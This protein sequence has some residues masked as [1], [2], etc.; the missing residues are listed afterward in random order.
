[1]STEII[2]YRFLARGGDAAAVI[3]LNEIP[4]RREII[5]EIDTQKFKVGDGVTPYVSLPY[6]GGSGGGGSGAWLVGAGAPAGGLGVDGDMYLNAA[7]GD[8][9]QKA[10]GT[11]GA[12][13]ANIKGADGAD[14][15]VPGPPGA[16]S[17]VPGP[18]G[19]TAAGLTFG[20]GDGANVVALGTK[21]FLVVPFDHTVDGW[22]LVTDSPSG[23]FSVELWR[24]VLANF[25]PASG[26]NIT[27][28]APPSVSASDH[29]QS[30][31]LTGWS[32]NGLAGDVY[33]PNVTVSSS[34]KR[35]SLT[36]YITKV[37]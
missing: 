16:D 24:D 28:S 1:M 23:S 9:Y 10:A 37:P 33:V 3:A 18:P 2:P 25:P 14:S 22:A 6:W 20:G 36:L 19:P 35:W 11:W 34:V 30:S 13:V 17:T 15:T 29:A 4:L 8:V 27:A 12:P 7:N 31:T 32:V 26:D 21:Q 5:V